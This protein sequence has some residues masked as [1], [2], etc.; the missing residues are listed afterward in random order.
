MPVRCNGNKRKK[1][2][3]LLETDGKSVNFSNSVNLFSPTSVLPCDV[4]VVLA[5]VH[6]SG[7]KKK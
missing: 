6:L 5:A 2:V 3:H 1:E 4:N 7:P